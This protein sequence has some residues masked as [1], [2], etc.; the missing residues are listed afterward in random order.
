MQR[1]R[2]VKRIMRLSWVQRLRLARAL[3]T[4]PR[5]PPV[6][7]MVTIGML[8]YLLMPFDLI[9]DWI[10][11]LGQLDDV[12]VLALGGFLLIRLIPPPVLDGLLADLQ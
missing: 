2:G 4:D 1:E 5:I 3:L 8:A 9:P 6:A 7:R 11:V 10:P 12:L